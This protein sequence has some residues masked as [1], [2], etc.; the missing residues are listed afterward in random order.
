[1]MSMNDYYLSR[2]L[3]SS[4][5][6]EEYY[7][8]TFSAP[9]VRR[10]QVRHRQKAAQQRQLHNPPKYEQPETQYETMLAYGPY[11]ELYRVQVPVKARRQ[12]EVGE[13]QGKS[14]SVSHP[15]HAL[16][17]PMKVESCS[18]ALPPLNIDPSL[19]KEISVNEKR[20]Q[21]S[22]TRSVNNAIDEICV[23][24]VTEEELHGG[25]N[26]TNH[27]YIPGPGESWMEPIEN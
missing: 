6:G 24:D 16:Q 11:G 10:Q 5:F 18:T 26:M 27:D 19:T 3:P 12:N 20:T 23:E 1:M 13:R 15:D 2:C 21:K 25:S 14:K 17:N 22:A 8:P 9:R 7:Y 4:Y